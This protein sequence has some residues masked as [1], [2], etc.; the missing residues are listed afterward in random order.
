[1]KGPVV[2]DSMM[3]SLSDEGGCNVSETRFA[4]TAG[5]YITTITGS[6]AFSFRIV[7]RPG[8]R[9]RALAPPTRAPGFEVKDCIEEPHTSIAHR[10]T[11]VSSG[12]TNNRSLS[13]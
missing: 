12:Q 7:R 5:Q 6:Q 10:F 8:K 1:M 2:K 9:V 4:P 11:L 13:F 3:E